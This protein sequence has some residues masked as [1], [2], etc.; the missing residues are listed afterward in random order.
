MAPVKKTSPQKPVLAG[1]YELLELTAE[2][3]MAQ[4]WRA[5]QRGAGGFSRVV[6][7][8]R[9]RPELVGEREMVTM[10]IEE[11]RVCSEL[12]HPNIVQIL[13]MDTDADD[14]Y[15]IALEWVEGINLRDYLQSF[16]D[17]R[18]P[19]PWRLVVAICVEVLRGLGAAH[20]RTDDEGLP[21]PVIHRDVTPQNVLLSV[22][23]KVKLSDFGVSRASDR[24]SWTSPNVVKGKLAYMAPEIFDDRPI[25]VQSDLFSL[26]VTLWEGLAGRR[27]YDLDDNIELFTAAREAH[28]PP[29]AEQRED[30]PPALAEEVTRLLSRDPD[31]R[32]ASALELIRVLA[33]ILRRDHDLTDEAALAVS[34]AQ[35]RRQLSSSQHAKRPTRTMVS[36]DP[37]AP[38][39]PDPIYGSPTVEAPSYDTIKE[40]QATRP[41]QDTAE[42]VQ[43]KHPGR[44]RDKKE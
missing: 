22:D 14:N 20:A 31:R 41:R 12:L 11:A 35:A 30:L 17:A 26:G 2:G 33:A 6:A 29:L 23:G 44:E 25:S 24:A 40:R 32:H 21:A 42:T 34:V 3:G 10:F 13:D 43:A 37:D 16:V 28:V 7:I 5:K 15:F 4:I 1:K 38:R 19:T 18:R 9:M 36:V 39:D 8:K 27:L